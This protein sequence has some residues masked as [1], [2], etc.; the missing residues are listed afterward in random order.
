MRFFFIVRSLV[1][2]QNHTSVSR[3][4]SIAIPLSARRLVHARLAPSYLR[5]GGVSRRRRLNRDVLTLAEPTPEY[6]GDER[7]EAGGEKIDGAEVAREKERDQHGNGRRDPR[8]EDRPSYRFEADDEAADRKGEKVEHRGERDLA[9]AQLDVL[10]AGGAFKLGAK[11]KPQNQTGDQIEHD[12]H[13][14]ADPDPLP[15]QCPGHF[16]LRFDPPASAGPL[17]HGIRSVRSVADGA[18]ST[19][20]GPRCERPHPLAFETNP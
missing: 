5:E 6:A 2:F 16:L 13:D 9:P 12:H 15:I 20:F 17:A 10:W 4:C 18:G 11:K 19:R 3:S 1:A 14:H 7:H 8:L